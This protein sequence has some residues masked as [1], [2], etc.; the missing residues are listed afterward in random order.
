L[1]RQGI[2]T[3]LTLADAYPGQPSI[4]EQA[5]RALIHFADYLQH[6]KQYEAAVAAWEEACKNQ[7]RMAAEFP[8]VGKIATAPAVT[9]KRIASICG[10]MKQWPQA[11]DAVQRALV[12]Q[13]KVHERDPEG[14]GVALADLLQDL[15]DTWA[16]SN[17]FPTA[18]S[19]AREVTGLF[20]KKWEPWHR[21][22][23]FAAG[24][25]RQ[26]T[27]DTSLSEESRQKAVAQ[28][29]R[30]I[31]VLLE[32]AVKNG[33]RAVAYFPAQEAVP[34]VT[35]RQDFQDLVQNATSA[36]KNKEQQVEL[37]QCPTRFTLNS[38]N[39][40]DPGRRSWAR[41]NDIWLEIHPS[42]K[43]DV[44]VISGFGTVNGLEGSLMRRPTGGGY[45]LFLP[46]RNTVKRVELLVKEP[47]REWGHVGFLEDVE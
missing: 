17:D 46:D 15:A 38:T 19:T 35:G 25:L 39:K 47:L 7:E 4:R 12:H 43:E 22:A 23:R 32:E 1:Q 28:Y 36:A 13:R 31:I 6:A 11:R 10:Q 45:T 44:F 40:A 20:P 9:L 27:D 18:L 42:G 37:E 14:G 3:L 16:E 8:K 24:C 5:I 41:S 2:D 33:Y 26:A 21:A 30:E 29:E 34:S